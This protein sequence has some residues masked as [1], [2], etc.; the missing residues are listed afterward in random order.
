[1]RNLAIKGHT[2]RGKE[3]IEI[4]EMLGG[5]NI[6]HLIGAFINRIYFINEN[7]DVDSY[8]IDSFNYNFQI[9]TLEEFLKKYP[10]KVGDFVRIPE[11]ESEVRIEKMKWDGFEVQY[12]VFTD[13]TEWYS[14]EEL[15]EYNEPYK[16]ET[17]EETM[18]EKKINQMSIANCDLDEVEIVLGDKFE[19]VNR[20]GKYYA[21]KKQ[22]KYPKTFI[23][24][25][26]FW[27]PDRQIEDDYQRCYKKGLIEKF[28]DLLYARDAY[29]KIAGEEMGLGKPWEPDWKD[30]SESKYVICMMNNE[31]SRH[32]SRHIST[33][34][35]F[36]LAFPTEEMRDA[37]YENFKHLIE[38]CKEFL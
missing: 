27:H 3:V 29:W 23:E 31:V 11:Y 17:K 32:I 9:F 7:E 1:M 21:V 20:E 22:S 8:R 13:E 33:H 6:V 25:L 5:K 35:H 18:E 34:I 30:E 38:S 12:L 26:Y 10:Y 28:Q 15:N 37:F 19:L 36:V 14:A 16:E 4:L 2:T 24:V